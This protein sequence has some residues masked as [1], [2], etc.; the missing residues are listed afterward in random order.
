MK[1][2][3]KM[4]EIR[5]LLNTATIQNIQGAMGRCNKTLNTLQTKSGKYINEVIS[6]YGK[7]LVTRAEV[8]A[9]KIVNYS[10]KGEPTIYTRDPFRGIVRINENGAE[11]ISNQPNLWDNLMGLIFKGL[12]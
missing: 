4:P 12:R 8:S 11:R 9:N 3:I 6:D 10:T 1:G 7:G 2:K 5:C